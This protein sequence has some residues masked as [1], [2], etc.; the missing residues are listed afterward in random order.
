[1][2]KKTKLLL[3]DIQILR[4]SYLKSLTRLDVV[5]KIITDKLPLNFTWVGLIVAAFPEAKI[6]NLNRDPIATCHSIYKT[7]FTDIGHGYAYNLAELAEF[8]NLYNDL[9]EFWRKRF[10]NK[11]YDICYEDMTNS[12]EHETRKL[13]AFCELDWEDQCLNFH[14]T[15]RIVN[16]A[17]S[18]QV[19]KKM[20]QGSSEVWKNYDV[21]LQPLI[22]AL[23]ARVDGG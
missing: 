18:N 6:I 7:K 3:N 21:Q 10:P 11:I 20:Y 13:L 22:N 5:E 17:S 12:Q 2:S 19:R 16:T 9:M 4:S 14:E 15:K 23:N 8:Y 1:M